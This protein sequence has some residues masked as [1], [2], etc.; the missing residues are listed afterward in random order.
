MRVPVMSSGGALLRFSWIY[1]HMIDVF[2]MRASYSNQTSRLILILRLL[3]LNYNASATQHAKDPQSRFVTN[4][5]FCWQDTHVH[6]HVAKIVGNSLLL[7]W[8]M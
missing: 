8:E 2:S 1:I 7:F 5:Y 3:T 6:V 4:S